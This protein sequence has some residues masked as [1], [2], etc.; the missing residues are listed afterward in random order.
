MN[1]NGT[2]VVLNKLYTHDIGF[3]I[4]GVLAGSDSSWTS[5]NTSEVEDE[6]SSVAAPLDTLR[7]NIIVIR[8]PE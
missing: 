7:Q 8:V 1:G 4:S 2:R 3:V 6:G 5:T